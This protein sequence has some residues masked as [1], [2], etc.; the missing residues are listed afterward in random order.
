MQDAIDLIGIRYEDLES[1]EPE[2]RRKAFQTSA[3]N[4]CI[5]FGKV[6]PRTAEDLR[7][8]EQELEIL[9]GNRR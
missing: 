5:V 3:R 2:V 1:P 4:E 9:S 6:S 7:S 8:V